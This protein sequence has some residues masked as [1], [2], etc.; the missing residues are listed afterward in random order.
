MLA[1]L[2][3]GSAS[4]VYVDNSKYENNGA[5]IHQDQLGDGYAKIGGRIYYRG[6]EIV[7]A[8]AGSFQFLGDGYAKDTWKVYFGGQL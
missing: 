1:L 3:L 7:N 5:Y 4:D 2:L 8:N 6:K